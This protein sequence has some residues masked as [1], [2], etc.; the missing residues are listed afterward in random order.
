MADIKFSC[1]VEQGFNFQKD[2]QK[3]VG[4]L[5]SVKIGAGDPEIKSDMKVEIP[6]SD[7]EKQDVV[8]VMESFEW[9]GGH[10]DPII[11]NCQCS[12][13]NKQKIEL[14]RHKKLKNTELKLKFIIWQYDPVEKAY[15]IVC[16]NGADGNPPLEGLIQKGEPL[17][18]LVD[19][20]AP[21]TAVLNPENWKMTVGIMPKTE[22]AQ[23]IYYA[24]GSGDMKICKAWGV[25]VTK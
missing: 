10:G 24:T 14:L 23:S 9:K 5:I 11:I 18:L 21:G 19:A 17:Q 3:T 6:T 1:D 12:T 15:F 8:G 22:E 25:K 7:G 13:F 2:N 4:H 16:Q 20:A